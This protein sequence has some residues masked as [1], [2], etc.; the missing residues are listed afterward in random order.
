MNSTP[1]SPPE[2]D[3]VLNV[4][5]NI[6]AANTVIMEIRIIGLMELIDAIK[7]DTVQIRNAIDNEEEIDDSDTDAGLVKV[8]SMN[9]NESI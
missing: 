7:L 1:R 3:K 4:F 6:V 9:S 5:G 2:V 8:S